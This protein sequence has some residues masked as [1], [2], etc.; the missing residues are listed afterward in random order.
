MTHRNAELWGDEIPQPGE[1]LGTIVK[2]SLRPMDADIA[3]MKNEAIERSAHDPEFLHRV[4]MEAFATAR[5][6]GV[7]APIPTGATITR[8]VYTMPDGTEREVTL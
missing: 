2:V 4:R 8:I 3:R 6:E 5:I 7:L 1:T